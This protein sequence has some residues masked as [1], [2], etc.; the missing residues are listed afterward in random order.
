MYRSAY[1]FC[2]KKGRF[3]DKKSWE[4]AFTG[5]AQFILWICIGLSTDK[6][7]EIVLSDFKYRR[8]F[9]GLKAQK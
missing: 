9:S 5:F 7:G 6:T 3:W 8:L 2:M 1:K 4:T